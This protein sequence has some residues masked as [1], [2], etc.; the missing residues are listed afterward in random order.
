[1]INFYVINSM[2]VLYIM[3]IVNKFYCVKVL[4]MWDL[5]ILI[6]ICVLICLLKG[7]VMVIR[8]I[9]DRII[10]FFV[11]WIGVFKSLCI[12]RI[13]I[14]LKSVMKVSIVLLIKSDI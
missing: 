5:R 11:F 13:L 6:L 1:M 8:M 10:R 3:C 2:R 4:D 14:V 7:M 9:R 12:I